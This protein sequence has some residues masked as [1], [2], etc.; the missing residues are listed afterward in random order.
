MPLEA[1]AYPMSTDIARSI[2][3][4]FAP[5]DAPG[6]L[7]HAL[8][9]AGHIALVS[10]FGTESI[11]L[12]D[13]VAAID[14]DAPVLFLETGMLF[15]ET[16]AYQQDVARQLGLTNLQ[17]V[18]PSPEDLKARDPF[19][20][21]HMADTDGCCDIRKVLPLERALAP[22]DGWITGRK[23]VH[24]GQREALDLAEVEGD[25]LKFNPLA[26]WSGD[27]VRAY[28]AEKDLPRHPL[29]TQGYASVGCAPCTSPTKAGEDP[30]AGRWRG[31]DK[32]ECGIHFIDG[33]AVRI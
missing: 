15:A 26:H 4:S 2:N 8:T 22:F 5:K 32:D 1:L 30:R 28:I 23:R 19:G 33:K 18:R 21:L 7:E 13:M 12:L 31:Q 3:A 10:S 20:R 14:R 17:V 24:G 6:L 27:E 11:V 16:L 9:Q 25:R 29:V